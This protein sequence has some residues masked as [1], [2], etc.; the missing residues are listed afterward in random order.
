[1]ASVF[2]QSGL[3]RDNIKHQLFYL[4]TES[5]FRNT[6]ALFQME[7]WG[8]EGQELEVG[9]VSEVLCLVEATLLLRS[10]LPCWVGASCGL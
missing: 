10:A 3:P 4:V 9:I 1:M 2:T 6:Q 8:R 5:R 7:S